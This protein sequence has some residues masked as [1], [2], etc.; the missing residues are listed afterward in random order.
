MLD[1]P[2]YR[3]L[4]TLQATSS[5]VLFQAVREADGLPII[6]KTPMA[7]SPGPRERER[8]RREFGILQRLQGVR[9]VVR[10]HACEQLR[11]RPVL[12]LEKVQG[13]PLS[14]L[15]GQPMESRRFLDLA[16]SLASALAEIHCH[17]VIHK[18]IKPFNIIVE[19]SGEA[20]LIDFGAATLQKIEH[21]DAAPPH[22]IEGTL[23]YMSPEQTGRMNRAVDYRTDFYSLGVTFYELLTGGRP[24]QGRD[25]LEWFHAHMAQEPRPPHELN[26]QVPP[27]LSAIVL[28]LLA[29]VAEE[30]YQSAE[31]LK[32]DLERCREE[33]FS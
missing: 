3:V 9:G 32:A 21:L 11:E 31:G 24:F 29:K 13:R 22:L 2:G 17:D 20:R 23:A 25:A 14:E 33:Q 12:L 30:R 26:P 28:K 27:A 6:I 7:P 8:Y 5:N 18:D 10:S 16:I 19:P 15:V 4:G 1:I